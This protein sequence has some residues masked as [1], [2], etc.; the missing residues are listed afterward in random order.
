MSQELFTELKNVHP[1]LSYCILNFGLR[2]FSRGL[3]VVSPGFSE[4]CGVT[5]FFDSVNLPKLAIFGAN[6]YINQ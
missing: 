5:Y 3:G 2:I 4:V 1:N 6:F